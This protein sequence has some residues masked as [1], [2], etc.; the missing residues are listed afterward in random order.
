MAKKGVDI[1]YANGSVDFNALKAAGVEFV[2]I[3]CG[4]GSDYTSQDDGRFAENVAKAETSGMPWG[5][6]LYSYAQD[7]DM[8]KSEAR[9]TLRLLNGRK[10]A[11]GVWYDVEDSTQAGCNLEA[12]CLAYCH[13]IESAGLYVGIYSML[14]WMQRYLS[15]PSLD[16][17]DKWV[18]QWATSCSYSKGYGMWQFTDGLQ[19]GGK[20]FDGNWA[21]K[22]YPSLTG[23][24]ERKEIM[25]EGKIKDIVNGEMGRINPVYNTLE[26]VPDY[27]REDIRELMEQG[28]ILGVGNGKLGLSRSEAKMA[29]II[30]RMMDKHTAQAGAARSEKQGN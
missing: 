7:V 21:Y 20:D 10:P 24:K 19:I 25:T 13:E 16:K 23:N 9:H 26:N 18:A 28:I 17:Y 1:S 2:I 30:K 4:Y 14:D 6:Y 12:V 5:T 27:W 3:R 22:D 11:Y 15:K 8:A 29:V